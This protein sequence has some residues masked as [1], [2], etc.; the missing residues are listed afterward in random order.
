M[1]EEGHHHLVFANQYVNVFF[2]EIPPH[3]TTLLHHHDF[4]YVSVPPGGADAAPSPAEGSGTT[5]T[6][7]F[8][9]VAYALGNFSHAVTNSG[10]AVVRNVA[11][12]LIREQGT[13]RNGCEASVR[14]QLRKVCYLPDLTVAN[15]VRHFRLFDTD[16]VLVESWD[17]GPAVT[18]PPLDDAMDIL[19]AGLTGV[20]ISSDSGTDSANALRG[21][22]LWVPAGSKPAFKTAPDRGGHFITITF[23]D[24]APAQH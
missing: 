23:K 2:V 24:S 12:E 7:N 6:P 9:R 20:T 22:E 17:L 1:R 16:E 10:E 11:I 5:S 8:A 14:D 21:G 19:I 18:T 4:Q 15:P 3:E 13:A